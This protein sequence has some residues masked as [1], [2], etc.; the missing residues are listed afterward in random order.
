MLKSTTKLLEYLKLDEKERVTALVQSCIESILKLGSKEDARA[1]LDCYLAHPSDFDP[2]YLI[3]LFRKYGDSTFAE[4]IFRVVISNNKLV[5]G[6]DPMILTLLGELRYEPVENILLDYAFPK[7][8]TD[9]YLHKSAV[10]GLLNFDCTE[11]T[12]TIKT[13]ID[14]CL[15]KNLFPEFTPALVCKL[16]S[17]EQTLKDLY[18]LGDKYAS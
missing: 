6:V 17:R 8:G 5:D 14:N 4:R 18:E 10:L 11:F 7:T 13:N 15:N 2:N 3:P 16:P 12:D 1:L 9:Y